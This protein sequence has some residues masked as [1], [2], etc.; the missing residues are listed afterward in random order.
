MND[1]LARLLVRFGGGEAELFQQ[2][3]PALLQVE[4]DRVAIANPLAIGLVSSQ[5]GA[6]SPVQRDLVQE[7][8]DRVAVAERHL[9]PLVFLRIDV[10]SEDGAI[11]FGSGA[12]S[13]RTAIVAG[14]VDQSRHIDLRRDPTLALGEVTRGIG[15]D[16]IEIL[17]RFIEVGGNFIDTA[18]LY[19]NGSSERLVGE[20]VKGERDKW[21]V[22]TKY[23][24]NNQSGE[25]NLS[26]NHRKN[27]LRWIMSAKRPETR[28]A[29][30]ADG[31]KRLAAHE[32]F[33]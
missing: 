29:R 3:V 6:V 5:E 1:G 17:N 28:A 21:V 23:T 30:I 10:G 4:E 13:P 19:T 9:D 16:S 11:G 24:F 26:G 7:D 12:V 32:L 14:D 33:R 22:A 20:F 25:V 15:R 2:L 18:N 31:V 8:R 27:M